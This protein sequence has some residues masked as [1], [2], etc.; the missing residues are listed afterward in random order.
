MRN[1]AQR[2]VQILK[3]LE[4]GPHTTREIAATLGLNPRTVSV[5]I[6]EAQNLGTL[7]M[8]GVKPGLC[9]RRAYLWGCV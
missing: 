1:G 2:K 3:V 5:Y 4:S 7:R 9:G 6:A 8:V